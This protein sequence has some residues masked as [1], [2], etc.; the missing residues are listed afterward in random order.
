MV[1]KVVARR[2]RGEHVADRAGSGVL[3]GCAFRLRSDCWG[4]AGLLHDGL[5]AETHLRFF[6][7][8]RPLFSCPARA[9]TCKTWLV[10][11][12]AN[13]RARCAIVSLPRSACIP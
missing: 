10:S 3:I 13:M 6:F 9:S 4:F 8:G 5:A 1:Q 7:F 2:N 11:C 12:P